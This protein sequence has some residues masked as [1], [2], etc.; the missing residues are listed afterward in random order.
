ML[1]KKKQLQRIVKEYRKDGQK[2]P[3][4]AADMAE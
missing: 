4:A 2:W 3:A 1:T